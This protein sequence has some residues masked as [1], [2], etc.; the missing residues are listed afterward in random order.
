MCNHTRIIAKLSEYRFVGYCNC[1]DGII[2]LAWDNLTLHLAPKDFARLE[3]F[4]ASNRTLSEPRQD[5]FLE[6]SP[7]ARATRLWIGNVGLR[8]EPLEW[9]ELRHLCFVA[10]QRLR[11]SPPMAQGE[12]AWRMIN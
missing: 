9:A 4:L 1:C 5:G 2:H 10:R 3:D 7:Q 12:A 11:Q 8:L 6:A